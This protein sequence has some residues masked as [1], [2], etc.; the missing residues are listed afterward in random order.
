M[1]RVIIYTDGGCRPNPG[2]GAWAAVLRF[3]DNV[4]ELCDGEMETTNNRME[5]TAA[6]RALQ[7]LKEPCEVEMYTDSQYVKNGLTS[8]I[9][10]WKKNNFQ[11]KDGGKWKPVLNAELWKELDAEAAR[12]EI[13]WRW[14]RGHVGVAD[15]ERC[16]ELCSAKIDELCCRR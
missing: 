7:A 11:R 3:G 6:L 5:L 15:N 13:D 4:R 2:V 1:K 16:D 14:V 8:W 9:K 12:H 10:N